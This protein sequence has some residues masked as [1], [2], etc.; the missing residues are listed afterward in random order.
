MVDLESIFLARDEWVHKG[1]TGHLLVVGG[2]TLY[3]GSVVFNSIAALRAGCDL[4]TVVAPRRAADTAAISKPDLITYPLETEYLTSKN[5]VE[6]EK[7]IKIRPP[8]A[9]VIGCGM[10]RDPKTFKAILRLIK[11]LKIPMVLDADALRAL[12]STK[13]SAKVL[14]GKS[15][16]L[17]PHAK[18]FEILSGQDVLKS[19]QDRQDKA[20]RYA[21]VSGATLI[22]KGSVDVVCNSTSCYLNNSGSAFMTKGGFGDTLAGIAGALLARGVVPFYAAAAAAYI[23]GRAG[24]MA[25][26]E[27]GEGV[28]A[29]DMFDYIPLAIDQGLSV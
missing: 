14:A 17:T 24:E 2:S 20:M 11:L 26:E 6:I 3:T 16:I 5:I 29:S 12:A 25:V 15:V 21:G 22:L 18:E 28:L 4:V 10:G 8:T 7:I 13:T 19:A 9:A 1:L 23:N 27:K